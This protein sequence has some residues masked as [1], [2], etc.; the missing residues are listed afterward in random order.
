MV[1]TVIFDFG[2]VLS[3]YDTDIFLRKLQD[4]TG[5]DIGLLRELIY[6]TDITKRADKGVITEQEFYDEVRQNC[7]LKLSQED[8]IDAFN[9]VFTPI[10]L[11]HDL[12]RKL[13]GEYRLGLLSNASE[14]IFESEIRT[15]DIYPLFDAVTISYQLNRL[16]P[17]AEIFHDILDKLDRAPEECVFIDDRPE[18][19]EAANELGMKG[20]VFESPKQMLSELNKV[21]GDRLQKII[22]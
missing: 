21:I 19:I 22:K 12:I 1:N 2:K 18:N 3:N 6:S 4:D 20:I 15:L 16:K 17:E 11:V 7:G 10:E 8:F 9:Q 5:K 13:K 14:W